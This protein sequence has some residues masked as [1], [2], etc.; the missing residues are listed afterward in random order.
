M[1]KHEF[2][3]MHQFLAYLMRFFV[4]N[5]V[6]EE[7]FAKYRALGVN[8]YHIHKP[9][10]LQ[11]HAVLVLSECILDVMQKYYKDVPE[12]LFKNFQEMEKRCMEGGEVV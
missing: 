9:K 4:K 3:N 12:E 8:P 10:A 7:Y 6:P 5:G 2:I 1:Y 11:Q